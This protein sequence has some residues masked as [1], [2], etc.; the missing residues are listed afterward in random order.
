[1]L[2]LLLITVGLVLLTG[3]QTT[4]SNPPAERAQPK[5]QPVPPASPAPPAIPKTTKTYEEEIK[6]VIN[7]ASDNR[8]EEAQIASSALHAQDPTNAMLQRLNDWAQRN[9]PEIP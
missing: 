8:W 2:R 1:M 7:L 4:P 9:R 6:G 5:Y 3:C